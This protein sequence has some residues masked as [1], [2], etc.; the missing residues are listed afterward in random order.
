MSTCWVCHEVIEDED[1]PMVE[2]RPV[3]PGCEGP[4]LADVMNM[5]RRR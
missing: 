1:P 4:A 3:H 5:R 2:D